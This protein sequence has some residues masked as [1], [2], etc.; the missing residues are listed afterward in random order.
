VS[1]ALDAEMLAMLRFA[2]ER[3][4]MPRW[5]NLAAA[6]IEEKAKGDLVTIADRE[7]EEF[8]TDALARMA[9]GVA[10]VG[11]EAAHS[12]PSV[13]DQLSGPCWI[14][15]PIDGTGNFAAGEG[16]FA[17][18]VALADAGEAI[19]AWIYDP[20]RD[21][22]CRARKGQGAFV[23]DIQLAALDPGHPVP[24]LAAMSRYMAPAQRVLFEREVS[25]H[26]ILVDAPGCAAEQYP[27]VALGQHDIALYERTLAWDHAAGSLFVN[28]AGGRSARQDASDYRVDSDRNGLIAATT[29]ALWDA[30]VE[31]LDRSGYRPGG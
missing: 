11:E 21:R 18:M 7:V 8:L 16:H 28:E 2:A 20:Q 30:F 15:D 24:R 14:I 5:R 26:F 29:P 27:L 25:P 17:T 13:L 6:D 10:V 4:I 19:A 3:S 12:D 22:L 31:R 9:P 23:D 1:S